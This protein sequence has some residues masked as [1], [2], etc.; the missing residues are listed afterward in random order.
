M[1]HLERWLQEAG[2][3]PPALLEQLI[4]PVLRGERD[5]TVLLATCAQHWPTHQDAVRTLVLHLPELPDQP[6]AAPTDPAIPAAAD[7]STPEAPPDRIGPFV[8]HECL[9]HGA[10][11]TV[12]RAEGPRSAPRQVAIKLWKPGLGLQ[13]AS[14]LV[15]REVEAMTLLADDR[16]AR[17]FGAGVH[18]GAPYLLIEYVPTATTLLDACRQRGLGLRERVQLVHEACLG[19]QHA[20][21]RGVLHRDLK[22]G[23][24]LVPGHGPLRVKIIDFGIA[25]LLQKGHSAWSYD[26]RVLGTP[27][28]MAPE[29]AAGRK[30]ID[31][32]ADVYALGALLYE[33]LTDSRLYGGAGFDDLTLA[34]QLRRIAGDPLEPP[35]RRRQRLER[36]GQASA[37][38]AAA[39]R[40]E[41]DWICARALANDRSQRYPSAAALAADLANYLA[42]GALAA[43]PPRLG[44]RLRCWLQ[45]HRAVAAGLLA[46]AGCLATGLVIANVHAAVAAHRRNVAQADDQRANDELARFDVLADAARLHRALATA[47]TLFPPG[48]HQ[49]AALQQWLTDQAAPLANRLPGLE[50]LQGQLATRPAGE[51]TSLV[52]QDVLDDLIA[53]IHDLYRPGGMATQVQG[54]LQWSRD[55]E[56]ARHHPGWL[57]A[58]ETV[59]RD[60]RFAGLRLRPQLGLVPLGN[61]PISGL[62][63]FAYVGTGELPVR[64]AGGRL[65]LGPS[66]ALVLVLLPGGTAWQGEQ[67]EDP[68]GPNYYAAA[69]KFPYRTVDQVTLAPYLIGKFEVTVQQWLRLG[70][71]PAGLADAAERQ[72]AADLGV[73]GIG[74]SLEFGNLPIDDISWLQADLTLRRMG[75]CLPTSAQWEFAAR[76]GTSSPWWT[77][78]DPATV[79][80]AENL[81]D[82]SV[83]RL[84]VDHYGRLF[85]SDHDDGYPRHAPV[86][87]FAAN[88]FGLFDMLG[89]VQEWC[90]DG[91]GALHWPIRDGDGYR[92]GIYGRD[93]SYFPGH[94]A[95]RGGSFA[96][97]PRTSTPSL[98]QRNA[99]DHHRVELGVRAA[100][101]L[102]D[103]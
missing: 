67:C 99:F 61:D 18:A 59:R 69:G 86:G 91:D 14:E 25:R 23:N 73:A 34:G 16:I 11:S 71:Q 54:R 29:Q 32:R 48:P 13:L 56:A 94:R 98:R 10:F 74:P 45:Q 2:E 85:A 90:R 101:H 17:V 19:V 92:Y 3:L 9:G 36:A 42:G 80:R 95:N 55:A 53:G 38:P 47:E 39:L 89:N 102:D 46:A 30:D 8:V 62:P 52:L 35:S 21:Q 22:P 75:L 63:E 72:A 103:A 33:A 84:P 60:P 82:A 15:E 5:F 96:R 28:Y 51:A 64:E 57:A 7:T 41:L 26:G 4:E 27:S 78:E 49:D 31:V 70:G 1:N 58:A 87:S 68:N 81:A 100:R 88:G 24:V 37:I 40:N 76:A 50:A 65:R 20:H 6:A 43:A 93:S 97:N 83:R 66:S 77:G 12:W 44:Y 79:L